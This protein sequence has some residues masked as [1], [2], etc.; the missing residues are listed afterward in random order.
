MDIR[1]LLRDNLGRAVARNRSGA[2]LL[3]G[4][5]D[6]S[7]L[8]LLAKPEMAFTVALKGF[9]APDLTYAEK[10]SALLKIEHKVRKFSVEEALN[11]LPEVVHILRTFDL[12]LPNDLSIYFALRMAAEN[13][14]PSV[15]T[16]DG[17]D[18]LFAG[19]SYMANL[20][21]RGLKSYQRELSENWHFSSSGLG[22]ALGVEVKQPFLDGEFVRFALE[23]S[24][25]LKV[26]NGTGKYILRKSFE[27]LLPA[28]LVWRR[29]DPIEYGSGSTELHKIIAAMVSDE[30][31]QRA[32]EETGISFINKEHLFYYRIYRKAVGEIPLAG[33]DA[34]KCPCCGAETGKY[35]CPTCGLSLPHRY[36]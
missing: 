9:H 22:K 8:A 28:E 18:E 29:K 12:A 17:S 4:G 19:Y 2:I 24:P 21:P 15:I 14:V 34:R 23:I 31:F 13:D 16:G 11:A 7:I 3:S 30:E 33:A 6:T 1:D 25:K 36:A 20:S 27:N 32:K 5:V 10:V 35:H 26:R